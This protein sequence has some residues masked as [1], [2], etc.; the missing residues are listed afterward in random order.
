MAHEKMR[1]EAGR[2]RERSWQANKK[3]LACHFLPPYY[4]DLGHP[5]R[6][7]SGSLR[8]A[9]TGPGRDP[10][11]IPGRR[12]W[13]AMF[14]RSGCPSRWSEPYILPLRSNSANLFL[15]TNGLLME[16]TESNR[17]RQPF[18]G[19]LSTGL[20][21]SQ[22]VTWWALKDLNL[23][24]TDYE[25]A[26]LT[27][28]LRARLASNLL[29]R[30]KLRKQD[31]IV[32]L[33]QLRVGASFGVSWIVQFRYCCGFVLGCQVSVPHRHLQRPVS[34]EFRQRP[35]VHTC[36]NQSRCERV[37]QAMP[38]KAVN[39]C[40]LQREIKPHAISFCGNTRPE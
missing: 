35:N 9:W 10:S 14:W 30:K 17:R 1:M 3:M 40:C 16:G 27:A 11:R 19:C 2:Q 18:Q 37:A 26:A 23:R 28:E 31:D 13:Q 24:P 25:S 5:S 6:L 21:G 33:S 39:P 32:S 15:T 36:H 8:S 12:K 29:N 38:G 20:S 4:M 22:I 7:P 34:H